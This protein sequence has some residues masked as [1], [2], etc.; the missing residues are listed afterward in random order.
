MTIIT[1]TRMPTPVAVVMMAMIVDI[2][3]IAM[4][5]RIAETAIVSSG[6]EVVPSAREE[7]KDFLRL[8]RRAP[9][10]AQVEHLLSR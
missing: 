7:P 10:E 4:T 2:A 3:M 5:S 8:E 6:A 1:P 9:K